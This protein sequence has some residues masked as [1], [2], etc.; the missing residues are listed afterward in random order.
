[1]K[2]ITAIILTMVLFALLAVPALAEDPPVPEDGYVP[3]REWRLSHGKGAYKLSQSEWGGGLE[4][5]AVFAGNELKQVEAV[6]EGASFV[7]TGKGTLTSG[8]FDTGKEK[9]SYNGRKWVNS[10][11]EAVTGETEEGLNSLAEFFFEEYNPE[12]KW[13]NNTVCLLGLPIRDLNPG[14]T[15]KWY[16]V[17][18]VDLSR[19]AVYTYP[20]IA[21]SIYYFGECVVTVRGGEVTTDYILPAGYVRPEKHCLMWFTSLKD[22]TTEFLNDPVGSYKYGEPVSI[23]KDLKGQDVALLFICNRATY[24]IPLKYDGT[25]F[26]TR[27]YSTQDEVKKIRGEMTALLD[28]MKE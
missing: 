24:R 8:E 3:K 23:E 4:Y 16:T 1:M 20:M 10:K 5:N 12:F 22:I 25:C 27:F 18:P 19:D 26:P 17:V 13:Y 6:I 21:G 2:K 7:Y 14:L 11:G 9:Y 15:D 28:T